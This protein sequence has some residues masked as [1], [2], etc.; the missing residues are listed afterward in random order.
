MKNN[1]CFINDNCSG[2]CD[3]CKG[4]ENLE[5]AYLF[6]SLKLERIF[7]DIKERNKNKEY[8]AVIGISGGCDSS[9]LMHL[10]KKVYGLRLLAITFDNTFGTRISVENI[11]TMIDNLGI[12]YY[13]HVVNNEEQI[14]LNRAF[15]YA[16]TPDADIHNDIAITKLYYMMMNEHGLD[17]FICGHSFRTEGFVPL[18]WT[19]MDGQYVQSVHDKFGTCKLKTFPNLDLSY[20]LANINKIR[21]RPLYYIDYNK[22]EAKAFL[23]K[24]YGWQWYGG[25]HCE[26]DYTK[27]IKN[28]ILPKKFNIDK[29]RVEFSALVKSGQMEYNDAVEQLKTQPFYSNNELEYILKRLNM[30]PD[31]LDKI[32]KLP[33]KSYQDYETYKNYFVKNREYF[34]NLNKEGKIP[35]TFYKKYC[36]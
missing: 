35:D 36:F 21:I 8:D 5:R 16:S 13:A 6:D 32:M 26:N 20:W 17:T 1:P 10:C 25:H 22:E 24:E 18:N 11:K 4:Y 3:W 27:F 34:E 23:Q 28:Y 9:Y 12:D 14:D 7:I 33:I 19:Y 29:R 2:S 30:T 31:E 15:L